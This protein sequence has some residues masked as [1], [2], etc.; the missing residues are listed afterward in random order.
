MPTVSPPPP[1]TTSACSPSTTI[2]TEPHLPAVAF[3]PTSAAAPSRTSAV[4]TY[5]IPASTRNPPEPVLSPRPTPTAPQSTPTPLPSRVG[6]APPPFQPT[7]STARAAAPPS[8]KPDGEPKVQYG[9]RATKRSSRLLASAQAAKEAKAKTAARRSVTGGNTETLGLPSDTFAILPAHPLATL[10]EA[11][12]PTTSRF[13]QRSFE[14]QEELS[15]E[16]EG[17]EGDSKKWEE[18]TDVPDLGSV[19]GSVLDLSISP[20]GSPQA[21]PQSRQSSV[22]SADPYALPPADPVPEPL[23]RS[24][25]RPGLVS[26]DAWGPSARTLDSRGAWN[27]NEG[28]EQNDD[29]SDSDDEPF[30]PWGTRDNEG[31]RY[32]LP[33]RP[34]V[35]MEESEPPES[36]AGD[37]SRTFDGLGSLTFPHKRPTAD[38]V[39]AKTFSPTM[40]QDERSEFWDQPTPHATYTSGKYVQ[41]PYDSYDE[42]HHADTSE[43]PP[44]LPSPEPEV[45]SRPL[46]VRRQHGSHDHSG[47][48]LDLANASF[49]TSSRSSSYTSA[50]GLDLPSPPSPQQTNTT[51]DL[52]AL[53]LP[54]SAPIKPVPT[55]QPEPKVASYASQTNTIRAN[56]SSGLRPPIAPRPARHS[57]DVARESLSYRADCTGAAPRTGERHKDRLGA[58]KPPTNRSVSLDLDRNAYAR[59]RVAA[60]RRV[61]V[62]EQPPQR[63]NP[64]EADR[65]SAASQLQDLLS[66]PVPP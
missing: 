57:T 61:P 19:L 1:R 39:L 42:S 52:P 45:R 13:L 3:L 51:P 6:S 26:S 20:D 40:E 27:Q 18:A 64:E 25:C 31:G 7:Y 34:S 30:A 62:P 4:P 54:K 23:P 21:R 66:G 14:A 11:K 24:T 48:A 38:D 65:P 43:P 22:S 15:D 5:P 50:L 8:P 37:L 59:S 47:G 55:K 32:Q 60:P 41:N 28:Q 9:P 16:Q 35:V 49:A 44:L 46:H 29:S 36:I 58:P 63:E 33:S 10:N 12:A 17:D 56:P 2:A 53:P